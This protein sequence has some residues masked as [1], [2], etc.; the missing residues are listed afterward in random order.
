[1][2]AIAARGARSRITRFLAFS[3]TDPTGKMDRTD[4]S[5]FSGSGPVAAEQQTQL[6]SACY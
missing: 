4:G 1:M 5:L 3:F 6:G 2:G